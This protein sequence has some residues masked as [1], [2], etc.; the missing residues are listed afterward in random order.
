MYKAK[1]ERKDARASTKQDQEIQ[2]FVSSAARARLGQ[3]RPISVI[4]KTALKNNGE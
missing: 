3:R 4:F 1:L 2:G